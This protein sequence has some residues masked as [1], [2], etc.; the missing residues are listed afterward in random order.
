MARAQNWP[1]GRLVAEAATFDH[2]ANLSSY[3]RMMVAHMWQSQATQAQLTPQANPTTTTQNT[4]IW[5]VIEH[6]PT[7]A[8]IISDNRRIILLNSALQHWLGETITI[9]GAIFDDIFVPRLTRSLAETLALMGRGKLLK[10]QFQVTH[11]HPTTQT[12]TLMATLQAVRQNNQLFGLVWLYHA[13]PMALRYV[14]N[15]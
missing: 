10:T 6:C 4:A 12:R 14:S 13:A 15:K 8:C 1:L 11:T 5:D 2:G 7:P 9:K 3:L